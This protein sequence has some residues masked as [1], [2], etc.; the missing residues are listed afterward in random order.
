MH[1]ALDSVRSAPTIVAAL[2]RADDLAAA[3]T[4]DLTGGS[5]E[6]L[7]AAAHDPAD[8]VVAIAA[9]HALGA[10]PASV[11][12]PALQGLLTVDRPHLREH[13]AWA[14]AGTAP[15]LDAIGPLVTLVV[16]GGVGGMLAQGTLEAWAARTPDAVRA[17][18]GAALTDA[19]EPGVRARL[20]ETL[21][22]VDGPET[23]SGL[24]AL[25]RDPDEPVPVRAAAVAALG[26]HTGAD[27]PEVV[28]VLD[29]ICAGEGP[30]ADTACTALH[31]LGLALPSRPPGAGPGGPGRG[32]ARP[33]V[34]QLFLHSDIDAS[35][36]HAGQGDTGGIA[37]LLV[38]LGDAL[39]GADGADGADGGVDGAVG[40]VDGASGA[41]GAHRVVTLSRGRPAD[42][43]TGLDVLTDPGHHF[44]SV[45]LW[46]PPLPAAE[47]W[48]LR[49]EARR[50]I[51][52]ILRAARPD[53]VH[54]RMADVGS[55]AAAGAARELGIPVVLTV[56]PDPHVLVQAREAAGTLNRKGFG[57]AD[58]AEHLVLRD[59]LLRGLAAEAAHLVLLPRPD[60][61]REV[62]DLLG[63]DATA[64]ERVSVVGEGVDLAGIGRAVSMV[65]DAGRA[66]SAAARGS[67]SA[68]DP[69]T[70]PDPAL[71][72]ALRDLDDLLAT[73]PPERRDLP[74]ALSVG[75][76]HRVKGMST[77]VRTWA[78]RPDLY[79]RCN[80]LVVGGD[81]DDPS[82]EEAAELDL[83]HAAVP[84]GEAARRGLLL[85]GHRPNPVVAFWLAAARQGRPGLAA[86]DG[87]YVSAS[88]KE[89]FGIA[90]LEA[91]SAGLVVVAPDGGGPATYVADGVTGLL[92]D[93]ADESALGDA[94]ARALALARDPEAIT[95][96]DEARVAVRER[97]GI[98]TMARA[99]GDVYARV[100][101]AAADPRDGADGIRALSAAGDG[102]R[103]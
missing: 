68:P 53:V 34:L 18:L 38:Q 88:L 12:R 56:A 83:I 98:A 57:A 35:L 31:D 6:L 16:E 28:L 4:D 40:G 62:H 70:A 32:P 71:P 66:G 78:S 75:R 15:A 64:H 82:H 65:A 8:D 46:G 73:L 25:A 91:T 39:V 45:P 23:V 21:G 5:H 55:M 7:A 79:E 14:L 29:D 44:A 94:V 77:L 27:V 36:S 96:A 51:R 2:R 89:E 97:F 84:A 100:A 11:G 101:G 67:A 95:R 13:A 48:P 22:L 63:L 103:T 87:V 41:G 19:T 80:L 60:L 92:A 102:H 3:A 99:L 61:H 33:A 49:V 42:A 37:T 90:I 50:G 47:A 20:V 24:L 58:H 43:L 76:L 9:V 59:R 93:T 86:T 54:L 1:A 17:H 85:A 74:L 26:D 10:L 69:A 52:R 72:R 81:L 30:L